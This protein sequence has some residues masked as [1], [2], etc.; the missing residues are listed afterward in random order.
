MKQLDGFTA[1]NYDPQ[2]WAALFKEAGAGYA[3]LTTKHHDGVALWDTR[4]SDLSVVK[5]TPA[6]RDLIGPYCDALRSAGLKVGLYFSHLDWSHPDYPSVVQTG[7]EHVPTNQR[8]AFSYPQEGE[9]DPARWQKFIG[10]HR[11]QLKELSLQ[12]KP[13]LLWFDGDWERAADQW[14]MWHA[15]PKFQN[16][17]PN[18]S[19]LCRMYQHGW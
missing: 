17:P 18:Y 10:F 8:N 7:M 11:G 3:V 5:K 19:D 12:Y 9:G 4:L 1:K 6:S 2:K 16:A 15:G 14:K 13:D